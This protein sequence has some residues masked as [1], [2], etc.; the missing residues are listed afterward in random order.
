M[1]GRPRDEPGS[2]GKI[3]NHAVTRGTPL[4]AVL[5]RVSSVVTRV[6]LRVPFYP[7]LILRALKN[8]SFSYLESVKSFLF[9]CFNF[10]TT[11]QGSLLLH[12]L[13]FQPQ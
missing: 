3:P 6:T 7:I 11:L 2:W 4:P 12:Y 8:K 13:P 1:L 5:G 9:I 10:D